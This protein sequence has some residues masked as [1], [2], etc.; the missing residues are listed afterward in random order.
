L[1]NEALEAAMSDCPALSP[2]RGAPELISQAAELLRTRWRDWRRQRADLRR[3]DGLAR[4]S[5]RELDDLGLPPGWRDAIQAR[6]EQ[7]E[8]TLAMLLDGGGLRGHR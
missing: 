6:R 1:L 3:L 4:L 8:T 5:P 2:R 7:H